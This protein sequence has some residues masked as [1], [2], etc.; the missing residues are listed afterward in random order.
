[1]LNLLVQPVATPQAQHQ[2]L[3]VPEQVYAED[4]YW[5]PP[6]RQEIAKLFA[7]DNPFLQYG[8]FRAWI[9]LVDGKPV[10]RVVAAVNQRLVE[11]EQQSVGLVGYF[12]CLPEATVADALLTTACE[13]LQEQGM[14]LAR[15]PINLST[16]NSCAFLVDGFDSSPMIMMPYNPPYY[17]AYFEQLG[18]SQAKDAYAY[19]FPPDLATKFS[20]AYSMACQAGVN[21]RPLQ[22][23]SPA[24]E[25]ECL[26]LYHL[27]N[28][29]FANNWSSSPRSE[30]EFME[31]ARSLQSLV[32]PDIFQIAEYAG[33]MVG[34]FMA[35]PDYNIALKHVNGQLN[36]LGILKF[37][38][39][40]RQ[41]RQARVI[42][43][44]A[45]PEHRRRMVA[46]ALIYAGFRGGMQK[47]RSYQWAELSWVF[48]DNLPSRRVVE[49]AGGQIY[50][51]YR[52]YEKPL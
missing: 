45:L 44:C 43:I 2:F 23:K 18:W 13:W 37:L 51:T 50:K 20:R 14:T 12:E 3:D 9:A 25:Q 38:W 47:Q 6:L 52:I 36:W 48:E 46:P 5:V 21:I 22:T 11:R 29:A 30:A 28:R 31:E 4:P 40:R 33:E 15:G 49:S 1:M 24:F 35:L 34:F 42:A 10:G 16:H 26:N 27:F 19:Q 7:P 8:Q 32:D 39:Y 41:I 17:P